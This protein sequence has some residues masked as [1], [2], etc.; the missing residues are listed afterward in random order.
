MRRLLVLLLLSCP[1]VVAA[2]VIRGRVLE[3]DTDQ[4]VRLAGLELLDD[5]DRVL[6]N[7]TAD[8]TGQFRVRAWMSGKYRLRATA[9]GYRS[10]TSEL[11]ELG[12]GDEYALNIRLAADAVPIEPITVMSRSRSSLIEI[13]MRGYYDRRDSGLRIGMG[14]FLD[15]GEI[16]QSGTRLTDVLRR[17]PGLRI[18]IDGRCAY[19]VVGSNPVGTNRLDGSGQRMQGECQPPPRICTASLYVDGLLVRYAGNSIPLDQM[20]PLEW[21]EALEVYRRPAELPAEFLAS[22]ACGVVVVWT[23]RG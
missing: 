3:A 10:V 17:V 19:I 5:R 9:L 23:R 11:L 21:V 7:A 22:G 13:A 14:R 1:S 8:S 16:E 18:H 2:Q 6:V 20:L 4:P 15:R 12:T